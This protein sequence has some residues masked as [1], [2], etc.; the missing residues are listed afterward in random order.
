MPTPPLKLDADGVNAVLTAAFP[1]AE[2][3]ARAH[4]VEA[5]P[6]RVRLMRAYGPGL[7]RPG[8]LISG[9]NQMAIADTAAYAL[10]LAHIGDE[11]MAVTSALSINFLR[12]AKPGDLWAEAKLLR[13]GRR[14]AVCDVHI[15]TEDEDRIAAQANVTYALP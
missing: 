4:V 8:G 9:P 2:P 11:K 7:L 5:S 13:L 15:W 3:G 10:V 14:L 6:G 1:D 12:G